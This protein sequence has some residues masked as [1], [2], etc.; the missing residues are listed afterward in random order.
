MT[1][2]R[3]KQNRPSIVFDENDKTHLYVEDI[4]AIEEAIN[5]LEEKLGDSFV[6]AFT[7]LTERLADIEERLSVLE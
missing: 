5:F 6:G 1:T 3:E 2:F 7:T 4:Q